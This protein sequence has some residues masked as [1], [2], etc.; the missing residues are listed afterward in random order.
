MRVNGADVTVIGVLPADFHLPLVGNAGIWMPLALNAVDR[1]DRRNRGLRV[2]ARLKPG[3]SMAQGAASLQMV[4][5]NLALA[6]PRTNAK[7]RVS[8]ETL[9]DA[10][11]RQSGADQSLI[12]TIGVMRALHGLVSRGE[13]A[14]GR[15]I[16]RQERW[17]PSGNRRW[18]RASDTSA[19]H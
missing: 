15:S 14:S 10:I 2:I 12:V 9:R 8:G 6:Y 1:A 18:A 13:S 3:T 4:Q 7:R 17:Q 11:G 19:P 16:H 5:R